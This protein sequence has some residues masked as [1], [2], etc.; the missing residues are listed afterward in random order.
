MKR[1]TGKILSF[2]VA[3]A[4]FASQASAGTSNIRILREDGPE[5]TV[6]QKILVEGVSDTFA[7]NEQ[8]TLRVLDSDITTLPE[9][10]SQYLVVAQEFINEDG[11]FTFEKEISAEPGDIKIHLNSKND[12]FEAKEIYFPSADA[13]KEL[14]S[15]LNSGTVTASDAAGRVKNDNINLVFDTTIYDMLSDSAKQ[16]VFADMKAENRTFTVTNIYNLFD[17]HTLFNA[18]AEKNDAESVEKILSHYEKRTLNLENEKAY[19]TFRELTPAK[20][21]LV[22]SALG[23]KVYTDFSQIKKAFFEANVVVSVKNVDSHLNIMG[24]LEKYQT[25]LNLTTEVARLNADYNTKDIALRYLIHEKNNISTTSD[26]VSKLKFA[27]YDP[28][29]ANQLMNGTQSGAGGTVGGGGGGGGGASVTLDTPIDAGK[30]ESNMTVQTGFADIGSVPWAAEAI[31]ALSDKGIIKGKQ[32]GVFAPSDK[33]TRAEMVKMIVEA[34]GVKNDNEKC[35]FTDLNGHWAYSYVAS[36]YNKGYISGRSNGSFGANDHI[37]REDAAVIL[38]R[39]LAM[40]S[41]ATKVEDL[42]AYGKFSDAGEISDYAEASMIMMN[43]YGLINGYEDGSVKPK[44]NLTRAEA[45]VLMHRFL[46]MK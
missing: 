35:D 37:T 11:S 12:T 13:V 36:A 27:V 2:V 8:V 1:L 5:G 39:V 22:Y 21:K 18:L 44:G 46:S 16:K 41:K 30:T 19:E 6:V 34:L 7:A 15:G 17:M 26:I 20:K 25:E 23:N 31:N 28:S 45:A 9:E 29:S 43:A 4:V 3:S 14:I 24:I 40:E 32:P 38:Y 42:S 10:L 33:I